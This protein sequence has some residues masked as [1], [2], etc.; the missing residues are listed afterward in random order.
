MKM[1]NKKAINV[2]G[3]NHETGYE[4]GTIA[5]ALRNQLINLTFA[6]KSLLFSFL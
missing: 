3:I 1:L 5:A 4:H 6:Q 2:A